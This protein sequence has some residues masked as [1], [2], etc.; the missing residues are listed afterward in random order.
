MGKKL[1]E[2]SLKIPKNQKQQLSSLIKALRPKVYITHSSGF[3]KLVQ[4]LTGNNTASSTTISASSYSPSSAP[5][6]DPQN[7]IILADDVQITDHL[8]LEAS[9]DSSEVSASSSSEANTTT[10]CS[11]SEFCCYN[12]TCLDDT[13]LGRSEANQ[14]MDHFLAYQNLETQLFDAE[15][16]RDFLHDCYAQPEQEVSTYEYELWGLL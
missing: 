9:F 2:A 6:M 10:S 16:E 14:S 4:E 7:C 3:K 13:T 11:S 12:Q 8:E 5:K 1:S 15:V